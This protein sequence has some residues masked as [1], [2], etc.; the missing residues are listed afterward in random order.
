MADRVPEGSVPD[1]AGGPVADAAVP[2][3]EDGPGSLQ[4]DR[5]AGQ[6]LRRARRAEF[7]YPIIAEQTPELP[8]ASASKAHPNYLAAGWQMMTNKASALSPV[9]RDRPVQAE[10]RRRPSSTARTS[11]RSRPGSAPSS[12]RPGSPTRAAS[13]LTRRCPRTSCRMAR[14]RSPSPRPSRIKPIEMVRA[15]RDTLLNYVNAIELQLASSSNP[16]QTPASAPAPAPK[17]AGTTP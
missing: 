9:P 3:R 4:G 6:L 5:G 12:S 8:G 14:S 7:P 13:F 15:V 1:P 2:L 10:R 11:G 16:G 17:P